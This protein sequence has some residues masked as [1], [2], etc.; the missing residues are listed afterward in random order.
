M[1]KLGQ[2][3]DV[4]FFDCGRDG[5]MTAW[6]C[7]K[8]LKWQNEDMCAVWVLSPTRD[9]DA[10]LGFFT[11]SAHQI[12]P[13]NVGKSHRASHEENKSWVNALQAPCPAQL[14][15]KFAVAHSFQ[16]QGF[17]EVLMLCAYVKHLEAAEAVGAKFLVVDVREER[18]V[19]YY[20]E[21]FGFIRSGRDGEMAQMYR[22]TSVIREDVEQVLATSC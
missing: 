20:S 4:N 17:G 14:L 12:I 8:A 22:P 1:R 3:H 2:D 13:G 21:R 5:A 18:L 6:F 16:G 19:S 11:L 10:V 7:D 9:A 15:G